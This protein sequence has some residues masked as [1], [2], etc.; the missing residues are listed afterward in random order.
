MRVEEEVLVNVS[1]V[2]NF[3]IALLAVQ[4]WEVAISAGSEALR[5]SVAV[6]RNLL[7]KRII[8]HHGDGS[9]GADR[10]EE[11]AKKSLHKI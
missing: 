9:H 10:P 4:I 2:L 6:L 5:A 3:D 1:I 7:I 11:E 8:A